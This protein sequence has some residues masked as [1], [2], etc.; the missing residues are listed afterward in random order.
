MYPRPVNAITFAFMFFYDYCFSKT[1]LDRSSTS[2]VWN[3]HFPRK[4]STA[5][6]F[7][8]VFE[9]KFPPFKLIME[10]SLFQLNFHSKFPYL[11]GVIHEILPPRVKLQVKV[12]AFVLIIYCFRNCSLLM[13]LG[14]SSHFFLHGT[15]A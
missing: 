5:P 13:R 14:T 10:I 6:W 4:V 1:H 9:I 3:I 12:N 15:V 11:L 8:I 7:K 2:G